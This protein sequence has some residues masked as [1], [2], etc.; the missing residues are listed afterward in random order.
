MIEIFAHRATYQNKENSLEGIE[1][2]LKSDFNIEIDVRE[3][4]QKIYLAHDISENADSFSDACEI[5]KQYSKKTAIHMKENFDIK[6][7]IDLIYEHNIEKK[8]F[9][10]S[11]VDNYNQMKK[12]FKNIDYAN[13]K[14]KF[15]SENNH[16]VLWC[17]ESDGAW[18][19]KKIFSEY[20]KNK[21]TIIAMSKELLENLEFVKI[22][23]EWKRLLDLNIDGI[24][25]DYP[26]ELMKYLVGNTK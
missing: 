6:N 7:I 15:E 10:F 26:N 13:Y 14:N 8:C 23:N 5:I 17:D 4:N 1:H 2:W 21:K 22:E 3:K 20:K 25:T 16:N 11:T 24:C 18:Y 9:I 19:N 12:K